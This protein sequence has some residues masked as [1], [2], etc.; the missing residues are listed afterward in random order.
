[1]SGLFDLL[2]PALYALAVSVTLAMLSLI[3]VVEEGIRAYLSRR[4]D[5]RRQ[6]ELRREQEARAADMRQL[7]YSGQI[8]LAE[9]LAK[10]REN[11]LPE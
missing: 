6:A 11:G 8:T 3:W 1:M 9:Y 10:L 7:F 4:R 5:S 2:T